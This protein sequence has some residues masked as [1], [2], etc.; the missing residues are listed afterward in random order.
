M[1]LVS[2]TKGFDLSEWI[3]DN[4]EFAVAPTTGKYS[5]ETIL[6]MLQLHLEAYFENE[7]NKAKRSERLEKQHKAIIGD[8][9]AKNYFLTHIR[10]YLR[11]KNITHA[12][13]PYADSLEQALFEDIYGWGPLY[14]FFS[15]EIETAVVLDT[16]IWYEIGGYPQRQKQSF[17]SIERVKELITALT[18]RNSDSKINE[19]KPEL[20]L[21]MEDGT[22]V[23]MVIPPRGRHIYIEFRK[24]VVKTF[25]LDAHASLGTIDPLDKPFYKALARTHLNT[26]I[27]GKIKSAK[28]TMLKTF[29][30]L[31]D[32][33]YVA[34]VTEQH[35][36]IQLKR[37]FPDRL[38]MEFQANEIQL[39]SVFRR[40]L[41]FYHDFI[42][43]PEV[44]SMEAEAAMMS[45]EKG[46]RGMMMSYHNTSV[47]NIPEEIARFI[48][49]EYPNRNLE[50]E[51]I[52]I[53]KNLD[54]VIT[55]DAMRDREI[56]KMTSVSEIYYDQEHGLVTSNL[57]MKWNK[58]RNTWHFHNGVSNRLKEWMF[59]FDP[60]EARILIDFLEAKTIS[61]P[62]LEPTISTCYERR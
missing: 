35:F 16:E 41:R 3:Q 42:L 61:Q 20:E 1:N 37:D 31:R 36:E 8:E 26:V 12:F 38:V 32:P 21:E 29:Y 10:E 39:T 6:A 14:P 34:A 60:E 50:N 53:G 5:Y 11:E 28:T 13:Y 46:V 51:I 62:I 24:F 7:E 52:R 40:I 17:E 30:G 18:M 43:V 58:E 49:N 56:K 54:I 45:C 2:E 9:G 15:S 19:Q 44:R 33:R 4:P 57:L 47:Q 25:T 23:S 27:A 59:D 22:R 55:M 48:L